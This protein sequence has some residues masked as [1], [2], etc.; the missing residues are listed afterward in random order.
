MTGHTLDDQAETVLLRLLRGSGNTGLSAMT[1]GGVH[2]I[3]ALR[4]AETAALCEELGII[5]VSDPSNGDDA[6]RRNR[7]RNELIP[8]ANDI[9]DRDV[10]PLL[11]RTAALSRADDRFLDALAADIDPTDAMAVANAPVVFARRALRRW[12]TVDGY[13]PDAAAI[14][15]VLAVAHGEGIACEISG[16]RRVERSEQHFRIVSAGR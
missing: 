3:L 15:R 12:L 9:A 6:I 2:P 7:V 8:L 10:A 4:R 13:P 11:D 5:P 1:P 14:D 16:G